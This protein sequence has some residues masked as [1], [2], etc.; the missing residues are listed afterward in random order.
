MSEL[1]V[2]EFTGFLAE[3]PTRYEE[4][5]SHLFVEDLHVAD[6][7]LKLA[8]EARSGCILFM[9]LFESQ[10]RHDIFYPI[11]ELLQELVVEYQRLVQRYT[12]NVERLQDQEID[13]S[14]CCPLETVHESQERPR[15]RPRFLISAQQI[16]GLRELGFSWSKIST[17]LGVSRIT[18]YRRRQQL[19]ITTDD[20][21]SAISNV[22]LD[23]VVKSIADVSPN[24]GEIMIRGALLGRGLIVQRRRLRESIAR[25]DPVGVERRRRMRIQRRRYYVPGPNSLWYVHS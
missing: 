15:G 10:R 22:D 7:M 9:F 24:S 8:D 12:E 16:E 11:E 18:L 14:F 13:H 4:L 25:V 3:L 6:S 23:A 1:I 20:N 2:D 21:Y 17:L 5:T 19:G